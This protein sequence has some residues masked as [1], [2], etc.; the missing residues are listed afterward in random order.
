MRLGFYYFFP[1]TIKN[2][3]YFL[4]GFFGRFIDQLALHT[5][6]LVLF[7]H[8]ASQHEESYNDYQLKGSN[9]RVVLLPIKGNLQNRYK[10]LKT[11]KLIFS[12]NLPS[13][14]KFLFRGPAPLLPE[15]SAIIHKSDIPLYY[16]IVGNQLEGVE[17]LPQ[18]FWRKNLIRLFWMYNQYYQNFW[19]KNNSVIVNSHKLY[20]QLALFCP[21]I[22]EINTTT[23]SIGDFY[24][25]DDTCQTKS[26]R[27]LYSG[28]IDLGKGLED[29]ILAVGLLVNRGFDLYI[30]F[31]G[32]VSGKIDVKSMLLETIDDLQLTDRVKFH[33]YVP[34]GEKYFDYFKKADIF[35]IASRSSEGFPRVIWEAMAQGLP[36][37]ATRVGSIPDYIEDCSI[38]IEPKNPSKLADAI[39]K[40]IEEPKLRIDNI[41]KGQEIA[42]N[43]TLE[44]QTKKLAEI[45]QKT[46]Q[47]PL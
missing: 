23:L 43:M 40:I 38:L 34:L 3:G 37:I 12:K 18:P 20:N 1:I 47:S 13:V 21:V 4:P 22:H 7:F 35:V 15:L 46:N 10:N 33:G 39:V 24:S 28:R 29:I 17:D 42:K 6:E 5:T 31:V 9:I 14:D 25:R 36:V 26:I 27:L 2:K 45:L 44:E 41:H 16:L 11:I 19:L 8:V 32:W 30:D